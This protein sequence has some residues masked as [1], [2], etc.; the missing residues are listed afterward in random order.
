M[1][2]PQPFLDPLNEY[3]DYNTIYTLMVFAPDKIPGAIRKWLYDKTH[4]IDYTTYDPAIDY[5]IGGNS[6]YE[7]G[8][9]RKPSA[10]LTTEDLPDMKTKV[11]TLKAYEF[12]LDFRCLHVQTG[13][14]RKCDNGC[15]LL[16]RGGGEQ[17]SCKAKK[18]EGHRWSGSRK[19][20]DKG[21]WC[22]GRKGERLVLLDDCG[23]WH[24]RR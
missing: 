10:A 19:M 15:Y 11:V 14:D 22:F 16:E 5:K 17:P 21:A 1:P 4:P 2:R 20:D 13:S 23:E 8:L 6:E 3:E 9:R 24:L 18:C 7:P 12:P